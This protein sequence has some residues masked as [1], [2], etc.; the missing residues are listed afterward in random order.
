MDVLISM[1]DSNNPSSLPLPT[2][3]PEFIH[4]ARRT[5]ETHRVYIFSHIQFSDTQRA[6]TKCEIISWCRNRLKHCFQ[7]AVNSVSLNSNPTRGSCWSFNASVWSPMM[8]LGSEMATH[9]KRLPKC[10]HV[11]MRLTKPFLR[12]SYSPPFHVGIVKSGVNARHSPL[13]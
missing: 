5:K 11:G 8:P 9:C 7:A 10:S 6:F 12:K 13:S 2:V 3:T 1:D 4:V